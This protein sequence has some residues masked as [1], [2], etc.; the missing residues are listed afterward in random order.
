MQLFH[1]HRLLV[2]GCEPFFMAMFT[3]RSQ[4]AD[5]PA[6]CARHPHFKLQSGGLGMWGG[7]EPR[8]RDPESSH[9]GLFPLLFGEVVPVGEESWQSCIGSCASLL[10]FHNMFHSSGSS[11]DSSKSPLLRFHN[12]LRNSG[13]SSRFEHFMH[14]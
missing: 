1:M 8:L 6:L 5:F 3:Q 10:R 11:V 14:T 12:V 4:G 7:R 13:S 2:Q 9:A